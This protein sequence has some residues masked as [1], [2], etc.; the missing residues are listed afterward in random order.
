MNQP[1]ECLFDPLVSF[2]CN[3]S[4]HWI[5]WSCLLILIIL[6][7][8]KRIWPWNLHQKDILEKL[9]TTLTLYLL[10]SSNLYTL[11]LIY[12]VLPKF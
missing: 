9:N 2:H 7:I 1:I 8:L 4:I 10:E 3:W 11:L 5:L 12:S 6:L